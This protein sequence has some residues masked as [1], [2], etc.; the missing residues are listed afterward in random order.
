MSAVLAGLLAAACAAGSANPH[1]STDAA[2]IAAVAPPYGAAAHSQPSAATRALLRARAESAHRV[3]GYQRAQS[4]FDD[5]YQRVHI[6]PRNIALGAV[7]SAQVRTLDVWNAWIDQTLSLPALATTG[8]DGLVIT[9]PGAYP[10]AFAPL[11]LR[12]WSVAVTPDGPPVIDAKLT[13]A[14]S[15][16]PALDVT[17][18]GSRL[19]VF[20]WA[21]DWGQ[22]VSERL[23]WRTDVLTA[24]YSGVA[25]RRALR[26]LPR[27]AF[28]F[29]SAA[30]NRDRA[31]LDA[32][33]GAWS[34]REWGL[35]I[36]PDGERL[37]AAV[38]AGALSIPASPSGR[39]YS[40]GGLVLLLADPL[41][42]E[43][44]EVD[45][46]GAGNLTLA[47]PLINAW[48]A[49]TPL[50]PLRRA[51][52]AQYASTARAHDAATRGR[53]AWDI[54]EPCDWP[55]TL[56]LPLYRGL[57][58]LEQRIEESVDPRQDYQRIAS[59]LDNGLG[60]V[61]VD[62]T[63]GVPV[64]L[65]SHR[66]LLDSRAA[67]AAQRSL[68]Y[69]LRGQQG[70][71][72][73]CTWASDLVP[74]ATLIG[75]SVLLDVQSV[76]YAAFLV[77]QI[78]RRDLRI[79]LAGGSVYYRRV[80]AAVAVDADTERLTLDAALGVT[81]TAADFAR[82]SYLAPCVLAG[83]DVEIQHSTNADGVGTCDVLLRSVQDDV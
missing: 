42:Y 29:A 39:D 49:G 59:T 72:W 62:D 41:H 50:L 60:A 54:S 48:P 76:G 74:V 12:T 51:R 14:F 19:V 33:L 36:W 43:A 35:P 82:V 52:L 73:A 71:L 31:A 79:E 67:A 6:V 61:V 16:Q 17:I 7:A 18:T 58:V 28:E 11:Q 20:G 30:E 37:S 23:Q 10:L 25:Q 40:A 46:V 70:V 65:H 4:W 22:S 83:D 15:A 27:R 64:L 5:F 8:A 13:F 3:L 77:G 69:A 26:A 44:A 1:L 32:A 53:L 2:S 55:T 45:S 81:A 24:P 63:A 38:A 9:A 66:W 34:A 56:A 21:P 78:G 75:S 80:V 47:R 57:P 68:L